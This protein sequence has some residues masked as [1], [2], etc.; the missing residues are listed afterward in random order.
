[1]D[2]LEITRV[3]KEGY[4][5]GLLNRGFRELGKRLALDYL[6]IDTHPGLNEE[7]L[8]SIAISDALVVVMRPDQ[9]D[10][11]GTSVTVE[12]A[13][14]LKM[15]R[16]LILVNK[17]SSRQDPEQIRTRVEESYGCPV[18]AVLPLSEDLVEL[19]SA[20]LFSRLHPDADWSV[21][22]RELARQI[23][24]MEI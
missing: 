4:D 8:L 14:R 5:V 15:D 2:M 10:F 1:M 24:G 20:G 23:E 6:I 17:A 21:G 22:L 16:I 19:A 12:V 3:L 11:Q 7:T 13:R 18:A 9:Q